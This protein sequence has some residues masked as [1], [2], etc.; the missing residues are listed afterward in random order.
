[1]RTERRDGTVS[2][3]TAI[4][5]V[6]RR[7]SASRTSSSHRHRLRGSKVRSIQKHVRIATGT[8]SS[9]TATTGAVLA[10]TSASATR[11]YAIDKNSRGSCGLRPSIIGGIGL[12][13]RGHDEYPLPALVALEALPALQPLEPAS[14]E[15]LEALEALRP[16]HSLKPLAAL[17][18]LTSL[19][20][21][22]PLQPLQPLNA[23]QTLR[24]YRR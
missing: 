18:A 6:S 13:V 8:T 10:S 23:L 5:I 12:N 20:A 9:A 1:M 2:S 14:L 7:P 21:L 19:V 24:P 16:L 11:T 15:P 22:E 3:R 17:A 4:R